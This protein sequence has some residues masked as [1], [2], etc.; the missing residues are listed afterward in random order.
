[1]TEYLADLDARVEIN[2]T[3]GE[4][5]ARPVLDAGRH[6]LEFF[7]LFGPP[8]ARF[9]GRRQN[10][11]RDFLGRYEAHADIAFGALREDGERFASVHSGLSDSAVALRTKGEAVFSSWQGGAADSAAGELADLLTRAATLRERF[12]RLSEVVGEVVDDADRAVHRLATS[13]AKLY[14]ERVDGRTASDVRFLVDFHRR[15]AAGDDVEDD[16]ED[17]ELTRA[18][19][20][21]RVPPRGPHSRLADVTAATAAWLR[22]V[23]VPAYEAKVAT[24]GRACDM[25]DEKLAACW[26]KLGDTLG[27]V[28]EPGD[29]RPVRPEPAPPRAEP[30]QITDP[31]ASVPVGGVSGRVTP[32]GGRPVPEPEPLSRGI[33]VRAMPAD[34]TPGQRRDV[35]AQQQPAGTAA[36]GGAQGGM[37]G[38]MPFPGG[39]A[40]AQRHTSH[41]PLAGLDLT[42]AAPDAGFVIGGSD[43]QAAYNDAFLEEAEAAR[44]KADSIPVA[45]ETD[46]PDDPDDDLW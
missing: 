18:A 23:F 31:Q 32:T 13:T 46:D 26:H 10:F 25:A 8:Y 20:L 33:L 21:C 34:R 43:D 24:F 39:Y 37:Y 6:G 3:T 40:E 7:R 36:A 22:G 19:K 28:L 12:A 14:A 4:R 11:R 1:M 27:S 17:D 16:V 5:L 44:K 42:N 45:G 2:G 41:L 30:D 29:E 9:T 35:A 38:G 15:A